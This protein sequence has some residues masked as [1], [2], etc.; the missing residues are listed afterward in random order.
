[1]WQG[2]NRAGGCTALAQWC[3]G[4]QPRHPPPS[5]LPSKINTLSSLPFLR[6]D[7]KHSF[8]IPDV[9]ASQGY[10]PRFLQTDLHFGKQV[11]EQR[12]ARVSSQLPSTC[13]TGVCFL[14]TRLPLCVEKHV[15]T[16]SSS[17]VRGEQLQSANRRCYRT[18]ER[19]SGSGR[20]WE[21]QAGAESEG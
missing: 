19:S 7:F 11:E 9:N 21:V 18:A 6:L 5:P 10:H 4:T 17:L 8:S 3:K 14:G 12:T 13:R 2:L 15:G 1:M 20:F 16:S